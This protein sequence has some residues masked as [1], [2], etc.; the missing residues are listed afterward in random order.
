MFWYNNRPYN[1]TLVTAAL[2]IPPLYYVFPA[3]PENTPNTALA[4]F[5]YMVGAFSSI[6]NHGTH[7][8]SMIY[9]DRSVMVCWAAH[10]FT[11][12]FFVPWPWKTVVISTACAALGCFLA[13]KAF[14]CFDNPK[15]EFRT[16]DLLGIPDPSKKD[17]KGW[18]TDD[19]PQTEQQLFVRN[20]AMVF[21]CIAHLSIIV[22]HCFIYGTLDLGFRTVVS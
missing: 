15:G 3:F 5:V 9:F 20:A 10:D 14:L 13:A 19:P 22:C 16:D 8:H 2:M 4:Q 21:H 18:R 12:F 17:G 7:W 1:I 11:M 6:I